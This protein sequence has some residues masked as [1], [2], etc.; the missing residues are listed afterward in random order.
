MSMNKSHNID[1]DKALILAYIYGDLDL[2]QRETLEQRLDLDADFRAIF[3]AQQKFDQL[4]KR[5]TQPVVDDKRIQGVRWSLQRRLR[6][7]ANK[8]A[9][10]FGKLANLWHMQVSFKVQF[11]S[12]LLTFMLGVLFAQ[13]GWH[14]EGQSESIVVNHAKTGPLDLIK[15]DDYQIVDLNLRQVNPGNGEVKVSFSLAS[16]TNVDGN[17]ANPEIQNLLVETMKNDVSDSTRLDLIELLKNYVNAHQ[18]RDAL[19]YS[20]LNDPNP[21]VRMVAAETLAKLSHD[22]AMRKVLRQALQNDINPGVRVEVFQALAR[23]LDDQ[24][25]IETFKQYGLKD[26]NQ[27]IR[28]QAQSLVKKL[29]QAKRSQT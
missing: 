1:S 28:D 17:L 3:N 14:S 24:E 22:K 5:G 9:S 2:K 10:N 4:L 7:E 11:A 20:L 16:Q 6:K 27:Y 19:I 12:M 15:S 29:D 25:T 18:V 26:S 13:S 21:G 8:R 23:H